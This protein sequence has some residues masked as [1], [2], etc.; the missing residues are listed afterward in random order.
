MTRLS[1]VIT[2][3]WDNRDGPVIFTTVDENGVP[4]A[5]YASC[6]R[7]YDDETFVIADNHFNKTRVNILSGCKVSLLFRTKGWKTY[8]IK[9]DVM[10]HTEGEI[11]ED[12]KSWNLPHRAGHAAAVIKITEVFSGAKQVV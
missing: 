7:L 4:N 11:F 6:V 10:Y 3:A 2:R 12:M 5:I 1:K 9:G 8:Q